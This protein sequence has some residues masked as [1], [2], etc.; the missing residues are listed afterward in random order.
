LTGEEIANIL[1]WL[2]AGS[3]AQGVEPV[4]VRRRFFDRRKA[5][6]QPFGNAGR[7]V[8]RYLGCGLRLARGR[9]GV[10]PPP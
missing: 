6:S 4:E 5:R 10:Y 3:R 7:E 8:P 2:D 1:H 9:A